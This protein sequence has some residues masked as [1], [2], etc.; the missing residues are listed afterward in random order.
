MKTHRPELELIKQAAE[1]LAHRTNSTFV[2]N[3][4]TIDSTDTKETFDDP[5]LASD[6]KKTA[7]FR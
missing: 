1:R 3:E 2:L 4:V 5:H 6:E 7:N